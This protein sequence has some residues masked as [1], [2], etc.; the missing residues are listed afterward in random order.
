MW[1]K[2]TE[3]GRVPCIQCGESMP[4]CCDDGQRPI[5]DAVDCDVLEHLDPYCRKCCPNFHPQIWDGKSIAGGTF[6][7]GE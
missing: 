2:E 6:E 1:V 3:K 5:S 4:V 7:R